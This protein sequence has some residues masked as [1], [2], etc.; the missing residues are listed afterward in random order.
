MTYPHAVSTNY[1]KYICLP[2]R[3]VL[4]RKQVVQ[5]L[6]SIPQSART[7]NGSCESHQIVLPA[8]VLTSNNLSNPC[9]YVLRT[10][11]LIDKDLTGSLLPSL[12]LEVVADLFLEERF[13]ERVAAS[14][15]RFA[16]ETERVQRMVCCSVEVVK[17]DGS[18]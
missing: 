15:P 13:L 11:L 17:A 18:G 5:S 9:F 14:Q 1:R 10:I 12:L 6:P 4:L 3:A 2:T 16:W 7:N 8:T